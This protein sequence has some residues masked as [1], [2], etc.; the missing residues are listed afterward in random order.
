MNIKK[1]IVNASLENQPEFVYDENGQITG[2]KTKIGGAD[3]VFPFSRGN[4]P[5]IIIGT[6]SK[7]AIAI[8][9]IGYFD[10]EGN[11]S[12]CDVYVNRDKSYTIDLFNA[13]ILKLVRPANGATT[14]TAL[15]DL[16]H[17]SAKCIT[18]GAL[19]TVGEKTKMSKG[20][21]MRISDP[22]YQNSIHLFTLS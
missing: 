3:S 22:T 20:E 14:V 7:G 11:L 1:I 2:Y 15:Q 5:C 18:P 9:V 12:G 21:S 4:F 8:Q 19:G 16:Y 13:N 17:V 6:H 10:E